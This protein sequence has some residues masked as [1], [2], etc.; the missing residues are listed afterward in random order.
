MPEC[1]TLPV[2]NG[3]YKRMTITRRFVEVRLTRINGVVEIPLI[4]VASVKKLPVP[5]G[6][7]DRHCVPTVKM[8]IK[9]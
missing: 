4:T 6:M 9:L 7:L 3:V 5:M 2:T 8:K 1:T